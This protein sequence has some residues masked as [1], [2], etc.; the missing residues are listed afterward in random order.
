MDALEERLR[1]VVADVRLEP[2]VAVT[3]LHRL[4]GGASRETWAFDVAGPGG[5]LEPLILRRDPPT[6]ARPEGMTVEALAIRA[7]TRHGVPGPQIVAHSDDP[8]ALESPYIIMQRIEG[9]TLARRILRDEEFADIRPRLA[10]LCGEILARI[11]SIPVEEVPGL[12]RRDP[13]AFLRRRIDGFTDVSPAFELGLRWLDAHRPPP[14]PET[15]VHGDF[16]NGNLILGPTA[17]RAVLDWEMVHAGDPM[18]DL[19]WLCVRAW[20]FGSELP[21]GGFGTYEDLFVAYEAAGGRRVDPAVVHWWEV[22]GTIEWGVGCLEMA[23]RHLSGDESSIE[24][25]AIGRRVWEQEYDLLLLLEA[26]H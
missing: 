12:E 6:D 18:E 14:T 9:E 5:V 11:H 3:G 2:D 20:R 24:L 7:A 4:T 17:V 1:A 16:R 23:W 15:V 26:A 22:Y 25:A 13:V 10:T 8:R 19:G 21:V